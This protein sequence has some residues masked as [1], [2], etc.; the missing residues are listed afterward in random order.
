MSTNVVRMPFVVDP[1]QNRANGWDFGCKTASLVH[2]T[3]EGAVVEV[4][5]V[6]GKTKTKRVVR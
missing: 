1:E 6:E 3:A 5:A 4:V 2:I